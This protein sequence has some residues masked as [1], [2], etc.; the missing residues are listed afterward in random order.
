ME[1]L[2]AGSPYVDTLPGSFLNPVLE[3]PLGAFLMLCPVDTT[4]G[5]AAYSGLAPARCQGSYSL[6]LW[7]AQQPPPQ[8]PADGHCDLTVAQAV[9]EWV[10]QRR[11]IGVDERQYAVPPRGVAG[12][13]PH[14]HEG[15]T[16]IMQ[17]GDGQVRATGGGSLAPASR[18]VLVAQGGG[19]GAIGSQDEYQGQQQQHQAGAQQGQLIHIAPCAGQVQQRCDVTEEMHQQVRATEWQVE[20]RHC[21]P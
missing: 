2:P 7:L 21:E 12:L 17:K 16:A 14:I 13:R 11:D 20:D 6:T 4:L 18:G 15:G 3:S 1:Q 5:R 8:H 10:E 9:D 19:N